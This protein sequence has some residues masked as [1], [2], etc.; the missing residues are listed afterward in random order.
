[1]CQRPPI[2]GMVPVNVC[3]RLRLWDAICLRGQTPRS[4]Q[5]RLS[6][7]CQLLKLRI[8]WW[9][10]KHTII[11]TAITP[12]L[13]P[14]FPIYKLRGRDQSGQRLAPCHGVLMVATGRKRSGNLLLPRRAF[15][16]QVQLETNI[17]IRLPSVCALLPQWERAR[18][19]REVAAESDSPW[20]SLAPASAPHSL[21]APCGESHEKKVSMGEG[22]K[23]CEWEKQTEL[24]RGRLAERP[25]ADW[26]YAHIKC[27]CVTRMLMRVRI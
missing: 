26:I 23:Q 3:A 22:E 12:P 18:Y 7:C 27:M 13:L 15:K 4:P 9:R 5:P 20:I 24:A 16:A 11:I 21:A 25:S 8:P 14:H 10:N 2:C 19:C 1:M 6:H 17:L